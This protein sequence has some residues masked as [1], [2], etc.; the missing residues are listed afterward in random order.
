MTLRP[1]APIRRA[2][3]P[4]LGPALAPGLAPGL[5]RARVPALVA[6]LARQLALGLFLAL[7]MG[8]ALAL[9][10][11][12][13]QAQAADCR[14][15]LDS[16]QL[17]ASGTDGFLG[18]QRVLAQA[19]DRAGPRL[20][21]GLRGPTTEAALVDLCRAVP[22]PEGSSVVPETL[23]LIAEY[24][25]LGA[26]VADWR[27]RLWAPGLADRLADGDEA[28]LAARL[29]GAPAVT[30]AVLAPD[31]PR[32]P[33]P[34]TLP[35][36]AQR[37]LAALAAVHARLGR[38][39][40]P[41]AE[42]CALFPA[43]QEGALAETLARFGALEAARPGAL[44]VLTG[45]DFG[46]WLREDARPRLRRLAGSPAA[47]D[48]L[49]AD[50][51]AA[52]PV[53]PD[54]APQPQPAADL[55]ADLPA[56]CRPDP[57]A[58]RYAA[59]GPNE[60]ALLAGAVDVAPQLRALD[61]LRDSA[62]GL[63]ADI[64]GVLGAE[65]NACLRDR[66][67]ALVTAPDSPARV[68]RLDGD[69]V[70][71]LAFVAEFQGSQQVAEALVGRLAPSRAQLLEGTRAA[72]RRSVQERF[73]ADIERAAT[74]FA[75]AAEPL[76][77]TLDLPAAGVPEADPV[78]LPDTFIVTEITDQTL[79]ASIDNPDFVR[80]LMT[81]D[82]APAMSREVLRGDVR[83]VLRPL[84][85]EAVERIVEADAERLA[86]LVEERWT[87]TPALADAILTL[88][89]LADRHELPAAARDRL[90]GLSYPGRRLM[91]AAFAA[92]DPPLPTD[93]QARAV[94]LSEREVA[95]PG[96]P[97]LS[98]SIAAPGCGCVLRREEH[99]LVYAF[100]P[101][102]LSPVLPGP[103]ADPAAL[104]SL[105]QVNFE[106]V[107]RIAFYGLHWTDAASPGTLRLRHQQRWWEKRRDFVTAAHR[108]RSHA[109]LAIRIT[110]WERWSEA[111]I[112]TV[113]AETIAA[114]GPFARFDALTMEEARRFLP[115]L[116]DRPMPDALTLIVDGY[117]G[118]GSHP[119]ADRLVALVER[120][121]R[122][123]AA[124]GQAVNLAFDLALAGQPADAP[125]FED[126]RTL[127]AGGPG[128]QA[129]VDSIL[130]F[131][132]RPTVETGRT[133][134]FRMEASRFGAETRTEILRRIL[135]VV[136]PGG[137]RFVPSRVGVVEHGQFIDDVVSF[138]DNF[139][140]IG[141]WPVP[142]ADDPGDIRVAQ[143]IFD[144]WDLWRFPPEL[145]TLEDRFDRVCAVACPNRFYLGAAATALG[146]GLGILIWWSFFSGLADR[147]AFR[148]GTVWV[149]SVGLLGLLALLSACDKAAVWPPVFLTLL[150]LVLLTVLT[151]GTYQR[152]RN[153]P[154][155]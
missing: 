66:I 134:R 39:A 110:G 57:A 35:E 113:V 11:E 78:T 148:A 118:V 4:A 44:A 149:G 12:R 123:L 8:L 43:P 70:A 21:D 97:R 73:D 67:E 53:A 112:E 99:A 124:R 40:D 145:A 128:G 42:A 30:A 90:L 22:F 1:H 87:M 91:A 132:E 17:P 153:G 31:G 51:R 133:I 25:R 13:A 139:G 142:L 69:G 96:A 28:E 80:A 135:P 37:G 27:A 143:I 60:V 95:D 105:P 63:M 61:A 98:G 23:A 7:A 5:A 46:P 84:A 151:F 102:W 152:A 75:E 147:I 125:L 115:T 65:A 29:A 107:E 38:A 64:L 18:L 56:S 16:P 71:G 117:D 26:L 85:A 136:P 114:M 101:F 10:P 86:A 83:R 32:A 82:F 141:F 76:P 41:L 89:D 138:Q 9:V 131:L 144:R 154:R 72:I 94:A 2:P 58:L 106:L 45:P 88:P 52:R 108:H 103:D 127:L 15:I 68:F 6:T 140:G 20:A 19:L 92:I 34:A 155:P 59:F 121:A 48:R 120:L 93:L 146:A 54:P 129:L 126:I 14:A 49:I 55:P 36:A 24:D 62:G 74:I 116:F 130:V 33:C 119:Q 77:P 47:V 122:P 137:H 79:E 111:E 3:P 109:D 81:T 150:V 104:P 100:Y 50:Y